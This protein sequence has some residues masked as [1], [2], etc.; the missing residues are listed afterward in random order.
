MSDT[1]YSVAEL[2]QLTGKTPRHIRRMAADI[3]GHFITGKR[4]HAFRS[5]PRLVDW[6]EEHKRPDI[7]ELPPKPS[8]V[9][10]GKVVEAVRSFRDSLKAHQRRAG[11]GWR[12][13]T[14]TERTELRRLGLSIADLC[15]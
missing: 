14:R 9:V 11:Q 8:G 6:I 13:L 15:Q 12:T 1:I 2:A 4:G 10:G 5:S 3:E 7:V